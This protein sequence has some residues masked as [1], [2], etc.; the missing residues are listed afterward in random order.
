MFN[1][2]KSLALQFDQEDP[3]AVFKKEFIFPQHDVKPVLYFSGNSLGLQPK[4]TG[5][6]IQKELEK[7][8]T[9]GVEGHFKGDH[10][11]LSFHKHVSAKSAPLIGA[12]ETETIVM[13]SLSVNLHLLLTSFYQPNGNKTKI[14][15]EENAFPS[16]IYAV[17]S[18]LINHNLDETH[19]I[20]VKSDENLCISNEIMLQTLEKHKD[21]TAL[22]L[23]S[24]IQYLSGQFFD[25]KTISEFCKQ[26]NIILGLDLAHAVGNVPLSLHEWEIDFAVWCS[27]KYL[28]SGP[29]SVGGAFIHEKHHRNTSLKR[30]AGWWSNKE[31]NRFKMAPNLDLAQTAEAWQISN[32]PVLSMAAYDASLSIFEQTS[33][34]ALRKKS[35]QITAY[36]EFLLTELQAEKK[37][38]LSIL[39]PKNPAERGA[40]LSVLIHQAEATIVEK[41]ALHGAIVD[42][43]NMPNG[44]G[45]IR[46]APIPLYTSYEDVWN[47]Y[48]LFKKLL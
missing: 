24:G 3:L 14:I 30:L 43:R 7:W 29:G 11:W 47:F 16:D 22:V 21:S 20:E 37:N 19:L 31:S 1:S 28:N 26:N 25:I 27:Y 33:I 42:W 12:L 15:I 48:Q 2:T 34:D 38:I 39:T 35:I 17:K 41:F 4:N 32:A 13:N 23:L 44:K 36:L 10:P 40:Q 18:H 6:F 5:I 8:A 45:L 46:I 9:F